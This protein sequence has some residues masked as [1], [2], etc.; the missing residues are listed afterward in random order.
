MAV[1]MYVCMYVCVCLYVHM[2]DCCG[3]ALLRVYTYTI[4]KSTHTHTDTDANAHT[5][6]QTRTHTHTYKHRHKH[7]HTHKHR[8][9]HTHTHTDRHTH[10]HTHT[11]TDTNTHRHTHRQTQTQT[12]TQTQTPGLIECGYSLQHCNPLSLSHTTFRDLHEAFESIA[13]T[14]LDAHLPPARLYW[15]APQQIF[16]HVSGTRLTTTATSCTQ[17]GPAVLWTLDR[18]KCITKALR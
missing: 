18:P 13:T 11:D 5:Q 15:S 12:H 17:M 3:Y 7:T 6:T 10:A 2:Y 1:C 14:F 16:A 4:T 8:H 9:K